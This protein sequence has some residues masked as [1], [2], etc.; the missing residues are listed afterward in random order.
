MSNR[1]SYLDDDNDDELFN[2]DTFSETTSQESEIEDGSNNK[3]EKIVVY[4]KSNPKQISYQCSLKNGVK[5]GLYEDYYEDGTLSAKCTYKNGILDG[6][7]QLYYPNGNLEFQCNFR[8]GYHYGLYESYSNKVGED[9]SREY[10][11]FIYD[12]ILDG[13]YEEYKD[14]IKIKCTY[15]NGLLDGKYKVYAINNNEEND[16]KVILYKK[17]KAGILV[18]DKI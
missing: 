7:A 3:I 17:Y 5:D 9:G 15:V 12:G 16:D 13:K 6:L 14:N 1:F 18:K 11:Y 2:N 8:N 10:K 4:Y